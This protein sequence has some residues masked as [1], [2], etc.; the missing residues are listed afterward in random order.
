MTDTSSEPRQPIRLEK[1]RNTG[2]ALPSAP[3]RHAP[4][5]QRVAV[6]SWWR[7]VLVGA[8]VAL[9]AGACGDDDAGEAGEPGSGSGDGEPVTAFVWE[10]V[11]DQDGYGYVLTV[12][13][14]VG[15]DFADYTMQVEPLVADG[16]DDFA[17]YLAFVAGVAVNGYA[18]PGQGVATSEGEIATD[19]RTEVRVL[20]A[21][22]WYR[23]PWV[24]DEASFA[25]GDAEWV[26]VPAGEAV[27]ADLVTAVLN[28]RYDEAVRR[29]L[30]VVAA[31]EP[32]EAPTP[33]EMS[34]E[35]D[36]VLTPWI[37]LAGPAYPIGAPA[38]VSGDAD[39]GE[40]SWRQELTYEPDGA[41]G[42][43]RGTV[44]WRPTTSPRP[45]APAAGDAVDVS[46]LTAG[47]GG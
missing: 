17:D 30:A 16:G 3:R 47:L 31:G 36:E 24:L 39:E 21:E 33:E 15:D 43:L 40:A 27:I 10:T 20:G 28:E 13:G 26:R 32:L 7:L 11:L 22:R 35:L 46:E 42:E 34:T 2:G 12:E 41:D 9:V 44:R 5:W 23:N 19:S 38:T 18:E 4:A 6:R 29:L 25:L 8:V 1:K 37:G 45:E 14:V